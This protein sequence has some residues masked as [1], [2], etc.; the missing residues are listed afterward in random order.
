MIFLTYCTLSEVLK[1][2][3]DAPII[4]LSTYYTSLTMLQ[5]MIKYWAGLLETKLFMSA[6]TPE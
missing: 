2:N 6:A 1:H 4:Y 5:A 3:E